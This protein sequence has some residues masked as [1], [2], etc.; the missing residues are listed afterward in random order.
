M[1]ATTTKRKP[2]GKTVTQESF[3]QAAASE[4]PSSEGSTP[5][6]PPEQTPEGQSQTLPQLTA[7]TDQDVEIRAQMNQSASDIIGSSVQLTETQFHALLERLADRDPNLQ[8]PTSE[9]PFNLQKPHKSQGADP[10]G[11]PSDSSSHGSSRD[12][13]SRPHRRQRQ[14]RS[15]S[16]SPKRSPKH[17][18]PDKLDDG[19]SPTYLAWRALLRGK[20]QANA[21]WW[22]TEQDRINYVFSRT[23]GKAQS[24]LEPR[25]DEE[26]LDPWLTV[27]EVLEYLNTV[28]R[29]HFET[30]Q[31]ENEFYALQQSTSQDFNEF[32]TEFARLASVGRIPSVTWR[33]HLWRK[34]N[35]EFQNR[36][37]ATHHQH[38]TYQGLVRECQR[39]SVDLEEHYRRFPLV[40]QSRRYRTD[41]TRTVRA[42]EQPP[43]RPQRLLPAP[44][45]FHSSSR[46]PPSADKRELTPG[47]RG[48][49]P[50]DTDPSK[51]TCF[52]C[53]EVGHFAS[54]CPNP[55]RTPRIHEIEQ[56][57]GA[58]GDD[59]RTDEDDT[60]ESE[61]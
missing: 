43:Q 6:P 15:R 12:R 28:F 38:P 51:V 25:I 26:S 30:E 5:V 39:L 1:P 17:D 60:D 23:E 29:N 9:T 45:H 56:E 18:D 4:I 20:L 2:T 40:A 36:L 3:F 7:N 53:S 58:S 35:R 24:F 48:S 52:N 37:L 10:D 32:H 42:V 19:T 46:E 21:D 47:P 49:P 34:L 33:S 61:N 55:R 44:R 57:T 16:R 11:S 27:D 41:T 22:P 8:V 13:R 50:K 59:E 31:C 14:Y 54:S